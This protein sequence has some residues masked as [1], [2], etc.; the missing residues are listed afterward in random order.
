MT[1]S[2]LPLIF[3]SV[4]NHEVVS[5]FDGGDITSDAGLAL[6]AAADKKTGLTSSLTQA[7]DDTREQIKVDHP[8]HDLL[9]ERTYA[10]AMGYED[11]NDLNR[12]RYDPALK[13][14][15][16]RLP[17]SSLD[18][19]GQST[20]SRLEN[21]LTVRDQIRMGHVIIENVVGQ[22]PLDTKLVVVDVDPTDDPCHGQQRLWSSEGDPFM[23]PNE[24][25]LRA[26]TC[27]KQSCPEV[28]DTGA[29]GCC[30]KV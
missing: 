10:I 5:C 23:P 20:I 12:L 17:K 4:C 14:F 26:W 3:P 7:I 15:C 22:L 24:D 13:T 6:I 29:D 25:R 28:V 8:V 27:I 19:A 16:G 1:D 18:L 2:T 21:W 11:A 30:P 9:R